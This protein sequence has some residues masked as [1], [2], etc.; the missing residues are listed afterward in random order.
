[1]ARYHVQVRQYSK[2]LQKLRSSD[3]AHRQRRLTLI[4]LV[5]ISSAPE[6]PHG[7]IRLLI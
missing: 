7:Q 1:M 2:K 3:Y 5:H 6:S 4:V